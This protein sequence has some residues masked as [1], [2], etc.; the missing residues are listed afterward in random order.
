MKKLHVSFFFSAVDKYLSLAITLAMTAIVARMLTPDEIGVFVIANAAIIL[1]ETMRDFGTSVYIIQA[2]ELTRESVRTAVTVVMGVSALMAIGLFLAAPLVARFYGDHRLVAAVHVAAVCV[3]CGSLAAPS[4]ALLRRDMD[5]RAVALINVSGLVV[6]LATVVV[7]V[8]AGWSYLS[9]IFGAIAYAL[10]VACAA[11]IHRPNL[12]MLKPSLAHWREVAAFGGYSSATTLVNN[13]YS[14]LPQLLLGRTAGLDAAA[15]YSRAAILCQTPER[16]V[17]GA[18]QPVILPALAARAR[19]GQ[20]LK[21]TYL[22][23][24]GLLSAV[25]WPVLLTLAVL[26]E[27]AVRILL[28]QQWASAAPLLRIMALAWLFMAPSALTFPILVAAGRV[29][30]TLT[31]SLISLTPSA[32]ILVVAAP[33]GMTALALS[34]FVTQ[35]LQVGVAM[36]TIRR[37]IGFSWG[38]IA[39]TVARSGVVAVTTALV[40]FLCAIHAGFRADPPFLVLALAAAGAGAGWLAGLSITRHPLLAELRIAAGLAGSTHERATVSG[41]GA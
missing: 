32:V 30:D 34:M 23:A 24:L 5:F 20:E 15:L 6:N 27:P 41:A 14:M 33:H 13:L 22:N 37:R 1:S 4:L 25:H 19:E 29:R 40:P 28:G 26:A 11:M 9:L 36:A 10:Y 17:V 21:S 7:S 2:R 12:W 35:P 39:R 3:V 8:L 31:S 16:A 38:E 18:I